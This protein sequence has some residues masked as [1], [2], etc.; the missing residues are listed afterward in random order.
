VVDEAF[1]CIG[2]ITVKDIEKAGHYPDATK[3]AAGRLRVAAATTV[4]EKGIE[5]TRALVEAECDVII[6]DTAHGHNRDVARA[7][8]AVKALSN[9]VQVIAGNVATA[10]ATRALI[11]AGAD[12]DRRSVSGR[13]RSAPR[14]S[15]RA[16]AC[17]S[18]TA[19]LECAA[20]AAKTRRS[21]DRRWRPAALRAMRPRRLPR[22]RARS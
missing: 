15:S 18:S 5:R 6:I 11:D 20:E 7:V 2:L 16:S 1:R 4:G 22:A 14:A 8:E 21:G 9:T 10:E 3:D 19:V 12:G 17:R 13:V